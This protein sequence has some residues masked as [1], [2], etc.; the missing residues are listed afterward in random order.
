MQSLKVGERMLKYLNPANEQPIRAI[1]ETPE[2]IAFVR[3]L[4]DHNENG[5]IEMAEWVDTFSE[6]SA[7]WSN[8]LGR[9]VPI[10]LEEWET[11]DVNGDHQI[12]VK[13]EIYPV[14]FDMASR[15]IFQ[16]LATILIAAFDPNEN[17][18]IDTESNQEGQPSEWET[19]LA[20]PV[21]IGFQQLPNADAAAVQALVDEAA[22]TQGPEEAM[23]IVQEMEAVGKASTL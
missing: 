10:P 23:K 11:V 6:V 1:I 13:E 20:S 14:L 8:V 3:S 19:W 12:D 2:S 9:K 22:K 15:P 21:T 18:I 7:Y 4:Y 16:P 17:G 5:V